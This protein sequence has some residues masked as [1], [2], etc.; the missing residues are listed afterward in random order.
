MTL[1]NRRPS[2]RRPPD[3]AQILPR[4]QALGSVR[5]GCLKTVHGAGLQPFCLLRS[6]PGAAPQADM[7][8]AVGASKYLISL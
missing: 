6:Y 5:R 8:R 2:G 7:E 1:G 4:G 3:G